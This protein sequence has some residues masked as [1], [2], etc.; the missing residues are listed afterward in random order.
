MLAAGF[1]HSNDPRLLRLRERLPWAVL[2][3]VMAGLAL[4]SNKGYIHDVRLPWQIQDLFVGLATLCLLVGVT[5]GRTS[6]PWG[7]VRRALG[8]GPLDFVG[9][10]SYSL[11]LIHAPLLEIIWVYF[12]RPLHWTPL[13]SL[14][15]FSTAG[16]LTVIG[17][18]YLFFLLCERPF[19]GPARRRPGGPIP[20]PVLAQ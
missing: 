16:L 9:T 18:A 19:M 3:V 1:A 2:F 17:C 15:L 10:F 7:W 11:Y 14:L 20:A 6:D 8:W 5:P 12:L 13:A 4:I